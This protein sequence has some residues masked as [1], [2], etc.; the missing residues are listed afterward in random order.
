MESLILSNNQTNNRLLHEIWYWFQI[1]PRARIKLFNL[2]MG[3]S[4]CSTF[5]ADGQLTYQT[6]MIGAELSQ[7]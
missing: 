7:Q 3:L 6:L 2:I 4:Y 1:F 5:F